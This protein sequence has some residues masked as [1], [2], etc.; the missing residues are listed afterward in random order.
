MSDDPTITHGLDPNS[1]TEEQREAWELYASEEGFDSVE[2]FLAD[3]AR[4]DDNE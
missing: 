1:A 4:E 2:A 3:L